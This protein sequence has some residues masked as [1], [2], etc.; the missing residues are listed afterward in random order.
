MQKIKWYLTSPNG[1]KHER[2][3]EFKKAIFKDNQII[4]ECDGYKTTRDYNF[5]NEY[6][7]IIC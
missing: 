1:K 6:N 3:F 4:F 2:G 5:L 7:A